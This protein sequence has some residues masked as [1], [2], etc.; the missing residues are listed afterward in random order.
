MIFSK[1]KLVMV[2]IL[3]KIPSLVFYCTQN[4]IQTFSIAFKALHHLQL[5][6]V[7]LFLSLITFQ[8]YRPSFYLSKTPITYLL[9]LHIRVLYLLFLLLKT[10]PSFFHNWS[11]FRTQLREDFPDHPI[12][13][14][15]PHHHHF[16]SQYPS[17][18]NS[19]HLMLFINISYFYLFVFVFSSY[20]HYSLSFWKIRTLS[21][22]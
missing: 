4:K 18:F 7:P 3:L 11:V 19:C 8:P 15:Y 20:L 16:V 22:F 6:L 21:V 10:S 13:P 9:Q 1:Y 17:V 2:N 14:F 5:Q 12:Q